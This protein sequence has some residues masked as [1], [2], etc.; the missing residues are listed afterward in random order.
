MV[1]FESNTTWID[2]DFFSCLVLVL[3]GS[4]STWIEADFFIQRS[5]RTD[6]RILKQIAGISCAQARLGG[7]VSTRNT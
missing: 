1:M 5:Y 3:F 7:V 2:A 4:I 6:G